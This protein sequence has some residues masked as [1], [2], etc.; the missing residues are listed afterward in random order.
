MPPRTGLRVRATNLLGSF[1]SAVLRVATCE[2]LVW[3]AE[4]ARGVQFRTKSE[5]LAVVGVNLQ[6]QPA[7]TGLTAF[8]VTPT[9]PSGLNLHP[10]TGEISGVPDHTQTETSYTLTGLDAQ[11]RFF[12][13]PFTLLVTDDAE[14]A[15]DDLGWGL[16]VG[17]LAAA[18]L[19]LGVGAGVLGWKVR[20]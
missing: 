6:L 13:L 18:A 14:V 15:T 7:G 9:L 11:Q 8:T 4:A 5:A 1:E 20:G 19:G 16:T 12:Q 3:Q 10:W 17:F 2:P